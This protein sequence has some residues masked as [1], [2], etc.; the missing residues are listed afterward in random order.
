MD[1]AS[2]FLRGARG[3]EDQGPLARG[4]VLRRCAVHVARELR[5]RL[6]EVQHRDGRVELL[7]HL[8][9]L[10]LTGAV[11]DD[12]ACARVADAEGEVPRS[13]HVR[14]GDGDQPALERAE[15]RSVP[16]RHLPREHEDAVAPVE[17]GAEEVRPAGGVAG[18]LRKGPAVDDPF[19]VDERQGRAALTARE[20]LDD[21]P[22]E[23][24]ARGNLPPVRIRAGVWD[25]CGLASAAKHVASGA[26]AGGVSVAAGSGARTAGG[27]GFHGPN[28]TPSA[29]HGQTRM[30][31]GSTVWDAEPGEVPGFPEL[32]LVR[33][34]SPLPLG[35]ETSR[36]RGPR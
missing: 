28:S 17:T 21:V 10:D 34:F 32:R 31:G 12:E 18:E 26:S 19:A 24:E 2:G 20:L 3:V 16:G 4:R 27:H 29:D 8:L 6:V 33:G 36:M 11:G 22:R 30:R 13:Q 1:D 14:A 25:G 23:V 15:H 7:E 9:D 35:A 5:A